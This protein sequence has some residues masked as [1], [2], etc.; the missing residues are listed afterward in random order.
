MRIRISGQFQRSLIVIFAILAGVCVLWGAWNWF[1]HR[2]C[3]NSTQIAD[4]GNYGSYLQGSVASPWALAAVCLLFI[5]FIYQENQLY[6]QREAFEQGKQQAAE[7]QK[8]FEAQTAAREVELKE[9]RDQF[10]LQQA[11]I[12]KQQFENTFFQLLKLH[13]QLVNEMR[14]TSF[15]CQGKSCF[16]QWFSGF[17]GEL[18]QWRKR[19]AGSPGTAAKMPENQDETVWFY[20]DFFYRQHEPYWLRIF[21]AYITS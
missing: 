2:E 10:K 21:A 15:S 11:S 14:Y 3:G 7:Q 8:Q 16:A 20:E 1:T 6:L 12:K 4:L 19:R 17:A 9:T 13:N 18:D 5:A